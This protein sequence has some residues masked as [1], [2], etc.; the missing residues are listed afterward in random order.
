[1]VFIIITGA[2]SWL[3]Y[4]KSSL[5]KEE[6]QVYLGVFKPKPEII[7]YENLIV[8]SKP[9]TCEITE[10]KYKEISPKLI[11]ALLKANKSSSNPIKLA[12]LEGK[13]PLMSWE[14]TKKLNK[15]GILHYF[16]PEDYTL[17][18]LSRV[19]FNNE[20]TEALVCIENPTSR[21]NEGFL[22]H[23]NKN[24]KTWKVSS[25]IYIRAI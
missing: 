4:E 16:K 21:H 24:N 3:S 23:L 14:D 10:A 22:V 17:L 25:E 12:E 8:I 20:R 7:E 5:Y 18:Y 15:E 6:A 19:G 11:Q 2:I 9:S 1:M 13:V